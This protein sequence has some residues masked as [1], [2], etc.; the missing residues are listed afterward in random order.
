MSSN[1]VWDME[2]L[3]KQDGTD[4][5]E[6]S[7]D[8]WKEWIRKATTE[9]DKITVK[10]IQLLAYF[11][12]IEMMAQAYGNFPT[13]HLQDSFTDFVLNFQNKYNYLRL[14]DPV[15]LYYRVKDILPPTITLASLPDGGIYYPYT[16]LIR[17]K[18]IEIQN[19][20]T[21]IKNPD[22]V[23]KKLKD[24]RYVDLLYRM[25]CR[26]SHEFSAPHMSLNSRM[27]EPYYISCTREYLSNSRMVS[28]DV[29]QLQFPVCVVK[30]LCLN[31]FDNYM[32]HCLETHTS[33]NN[34][35][36]MDRFCELSWYTR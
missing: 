26:L 25:R 12:I 3:L 35:N 19:A 21:N 13:K 22:Y 30:E 18:A 33:P 1:K 27:A 7:V 2:I 29:W 28:D 24:H 36:S 9:I 4:Y 23:E 11:S 14:T 16:T 17:E 6:Y 34:N 8:S 10:E 31:C 32:K 5:I 15:T 20:I